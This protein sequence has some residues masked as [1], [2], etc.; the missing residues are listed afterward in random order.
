MLS[1]VAASPLPDLILKQSLLY[2]VAFVS[3]EFSNKLTACRVLNYITVA[4]FKLVDYPLKFFLLTCH[5][6]SAIRIK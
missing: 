4:D 5:S 2:L 3:F 6:S 1:A